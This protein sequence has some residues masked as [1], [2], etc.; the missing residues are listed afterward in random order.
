LSLA[1][2]T[3]REHVLE[4]FFFCL[5]Q[6]KREMD[7][8]CKVPLKNFLDTG[9]GDKVAMKCASLQQVKTFGMCTVL[10]VAM[11]LLHLKTSAALKK[12]DENPSPTL[13]PPLVFPLWIALLPLAYVAMST[14]SHGAKALNKWNGEQLNYE[15]SGMKKHEYLMYRSADER[16]PNP[17]LAFGPPAI[18][19][20]SNIFGPYLRGDR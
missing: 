3:R 19:G 10:S 14:A 9:Q 13:A 4:T 11:I 1:L 20:A 2:G 5:Y 6:T 8:E 15:T 12:Y 18:L 7:V 16:V 17:A